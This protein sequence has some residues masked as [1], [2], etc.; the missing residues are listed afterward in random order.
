MKINR[1]SVRITIITFWFV[2]LFF[3]TP[4]AI[5][6]DFQRFPPPDKVRRIIT[7]TRVEP[8]VRFFHLTSEDGLSQNNVRTFF[9]DSRGFMWI[10]T[11]DGLNRFDGYHFTIYKNVPGD[12]Q[13][14]SA[15]H[16]TSILEDKQGMLWIGTQ[17]G[18][19]N[20]FDPI[21]EKFKRF[22]HSSQNSN[23]IG[24]ND[25]FSIFEQSNGHL[26]FGGP[27]GGG[28]SSYDPETNKFSR[29][30]PEPSNPNGFHGRA[31][32]NFLEEEGILWM[33]AESNLE[34]LNLR[35]MQFSQYYVSQQERRLAGLVRDS[36]GI[37]WVAGTTGLY[38]LDSKTDQLI[39]HFP[40]VR[41]NLETI[42]LDSKGLIWLGGPQGLCRFDPELDQI[43]HHYI[44]TTTDPNS[45]SKRHILSIYEDQEGV[46]WIGALNGGVNLLD[47]RRSQFTTYKH[48]PENPQLFPS[49]EIYAVMGDGVGGLWF[50][51]QGMLNRLDLQSGKVDSNT[52]KQHGVFVDGLIKAI[53]VDTEGVIWSGA[54]D[55]I[56]RLDPYYN[57]AGSYSLERN[58]GPGRRGMGPIKDIASIQQDDHAVLWVSITR[59][60]LVLW[61]L[62]TDKMKNRID[63]PIANMGMDNNQ[64]SILNNDTTVLFKDRKGD[65]W[66][67]YVDNM[68]SRFDFKKQKI[69][70]YF[71]RPD[72]PKAVFPSNAGA[73]HED[74]AGNLWIAGS[75]G[76]ARF[77]PETKDLALYTG[78]TSL[79]S[80]LFVSIE[81]DKAGN[82]WIASKKGIFRF[83]PQTKAFRHYD[84]A[85]GLQFN[86]F[87]PASWKTEDG[88]IFFAGSKG[89]TSFYPEQI[90]DN[91][92]P[93]PVL[94]TEMRL[95]N[96]P[97]TAS[98]NSILK[99][100]IWATKNLVL[101]HRDKIVSFEFAALSFSAPHKN[102]YRYRLEGLEKNW[103][104]VNSKRRFATYTDLDP[105]TYTFKVQATNNS[106]LWSD[107]EVA[108]SIIILP[109]WWET[110]W[111]RSL[112]L[113]F[114]LGLALAGYKWRVQ[115][116][117]LQNR[118]LEAQVK[119]RTKELNQEK[120]KAVMLKE[121]A[122]VANHAKSEFLSNMSH[123]LRTPLNGILGY[124]QIL[125]RRNDLGRTIRDGLDIIHQSGN[126][127]LTLIND[128]LDM[129]KIEARKMELYPEAMHLPSFLEGVAGIIRMRAQQ[130][131]V[132][133]VQTWGKMPSG[134]IADEKRL[135]QV[136]LNLLGNAV[137]FT[138]SGGTVTLHANEE[139]HPQ[140]KAKASKIMIRFEVSDTGVG[141]TDEQLSQIFNPFEQVG[142]TGKRSEGTGLGLT[143]SKQLTTLMGSDLQVESSY[144]KGSKF[145]FEAEFSKVDV[146]AQASP[147]VQEKVTG[148][149]GK[150]RKILVVDDHKENRLV[151]LSLLEPIGFAITL[152]E[153]GKEG[154]KKAK[155]DF[156]DI[157]LMD[158]VMPV[159]NGYEAIQAIKKIP[160]LSDTPIIAVSASSIDVSADNVNK[161]GCVDFIEKPV[162]AKQILD[163]LQNHL[164]IEW[165][166]EKKPEQSQES[167]EDYEQTEFIIP[168][169]EEID[170][171][172]ELAM[173][174]D[175]EKLAQ[176][177]TYLEEQDA[178]LHHFAK[179]LR[180]LA[181]EYEDRKILALI[182]ECKEKKQNAP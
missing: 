98:E 1:I 143:I 169:E 181:H 33:A 31:V 138:Q 81:E 127:L 153:N 55:Y 60:G 5:A 180:Q 69:S 142:D 78:K 121:K 30:S 62:A 139:E 56:Y 16:I 101:T 126:Y 105:G 7:P 12:L 159:M 155:R 165:N 93:P 147:Q 172:Y 68:L 20:R 52:L 171:L 36:K 163:C 14:L 136:L 141:M 32:W 178:D 118:L 48:D 145:W 148:Y 128:I 35:T 54:K 67:G 103:N 84:I 167:K 85:D 102:Q 57:E 3:A 115:A 87:L 21:T 45:L 106:G 92:Y 18:G 71:S 53:F 100:P 76:L 27:P 46:L 122:E 182:E 117:K 43:T 113:L 90:K 4:W 108:L 99:Q 170:E 96:E 179:K 123:E 97:I 15:N 86:D 116:I 134:I 22:Q 91:T 66:I 83:N 50:S 77:N 61:D 162:E 29:Y 41:L 75:G 112:M 137:K 17:G 132:K 166:Y 135:R 140:P 131:D 8:G 95:F 157:I 107:Q 74:R 23:T 104:K 65:M 64:D 49:G 10:G 72:D 25:V 79:P 119:K 58:R 173:F 164:K 73:I 6:Q 63:A 19:V 70:H 9:Q 154:V 88:R 26:W 129:S 89:L 42:F 59:G 82:L 177:A 110:I 37:L 38:H 152:A 130:N 40:E 149:Q 39:Q 144:G 47:P 150:Q 44:S 120:E 28:F 2:V 176:K 24:G 80:A 109:P 111:F 161:I 156:P 168:S 94:L 11:Q 151:L 114:F 175:M 124:A 174:G 125:K 51:S 146:Q 158:L 13:S 133:F 34:K 160:N